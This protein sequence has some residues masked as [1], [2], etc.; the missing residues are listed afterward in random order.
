[1]PGA[2]SGDEFDFCQGSRNKNRLLILSL[3]N[4]NVSGLARGAFISIEAT[5]VET[6]L[7]AICGFC[8]LAFLFSLYL[9][10]RTYELWGAIWLFLL[11]NLADHR[12]YSSVSDYGYRT[13]PLA[14]KVFFF[15]GL[16]LESEEFFAERCRG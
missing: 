9:H 13:A 16:Q 8:V 2:Y 1:M 7:L 11:K 10:F 4:P 15:G 3:D 6:L 12:I 5:P 14:K